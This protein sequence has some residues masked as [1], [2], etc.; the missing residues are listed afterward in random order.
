[1]NIGSRHFDHVTHVD[2]EFVVRT[3][4][5]PCPVVCMVVM[6]HVTDNVRRYWMDELLTLSAPP[7]PTDDRSLVVAYYSAA[8]WSCFLQLGWL[9]PQNTLD[10]FTEFRN[11]TN[12]LPLR[13]GAGLLGALVYF[14]LDAMAAVEKSEMHDLILKGEP[15]S[16]EERVAI[17]DY[18]E[19]DVHALKRLLIA[20]E[21][22]V[23]IARALLRGRYMRAVA[24]MERNGV[25]IDV[26]KWPLLRDRWE[27]IQDELIQKVNRNFGFYDGRTFKS[28][29]FR[30]YLRT[31]DMSW[32]ILPSG[33]LDMSK[34]TW[35]DMVGVYPQLLEVHYLRSMLS[36]M[37]LHDLAVGPD[38]RNRSMLSAFRSVT[39][40]NQPSNSK[41]ILGMSSWLRGLIQPP[42][43]MALAY[44]DYS[45]QEI[46]IAAALS[47]DDKLIAAYQS[48]DAY[49][50]FAKQAGAI[51]SD[52]TKKLHGKIREQFKQCMLAVQYGMGAESLAIR[53]G[54]SVF[55][56]RELLRMH[57]RTYSIYWAWSKGACDFARLFGYLPTVFGWNLHLATDVKDRTIQNF[58]MQA[59]GAEML[60]LA[61]CLLTEAGV[62][63]CAPVHDAVLIEAPMEEIE[64]A[65]AETQRLME[66]A[67]AEV[68]DGFRLRSDVK[69]IRHPDRF[70]DERGTSMWDSVWSLIPGGGA[71]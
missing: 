66:E 43:G 45:Q 1:M 13:S 70:L 10:L 8:E 60:R 69:V 15:Y 7:F 42:P 19:A 24:F 17:L 22:K 39:G 40:R 6:D 48:G 29:R 67:S 71:R 64:S 21:S 34:D 46:G 18:C 32:P 3:G 23:D 28:D 25:P 27:L 38:G 61:C 11:L 65:V 63:A 36:K 49:L 62:K 4:S 54:Q 44:I 53:I 35:S 55:Q 51:P 41:F 57:Q 14:G 30:D 37:K 33:S 56:A 31:N 52:G 59:N 50:E 2:F 47:H 26:E 68:L 9:L 5:T 20:M 58:P 16:D 12:G